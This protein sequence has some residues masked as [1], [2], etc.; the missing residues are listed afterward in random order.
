M[1]TYGKRLDAALAAKAPKDRTWLAAQ[2]GVT[3]QALS[4]VI[5]GKTKALTAENHEGV[6]HWFENK[7]KNACKRLLKYAL[8]HSSPQSSGKE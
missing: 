6:Y 4:Q 3:V 8:I 5:I 7:L 2:I 1:D